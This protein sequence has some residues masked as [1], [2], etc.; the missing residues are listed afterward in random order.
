MGGRGY[1]KNL[2][3]SV[4]LDFPITLR[5]AIQIFFFLTGRILKT[6]LYP[7]LQMDIIPLV[8]IGQKCFLELTCI[9]ITIFYSETT[10]RNYAI[11]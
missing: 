7:S 11:V 9:L 4:T 10:C 5:N 8:L 3:M 6:V 2:Y 1:I